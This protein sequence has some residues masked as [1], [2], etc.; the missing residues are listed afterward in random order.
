MVTPAVPPLPVYIIIKTSLSKVFGMW[1]VIVD[2]GSWESYL[3]PEEHLH[4]RDHAG[5]DVLSPERGD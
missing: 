4:I 5:D 2:L 3:M 1:R